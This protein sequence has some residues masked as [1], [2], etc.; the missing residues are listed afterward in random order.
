MI[1]CICKAITEKDIKDCITDCSH[2]SNKDVLH[3]LKIGSS[4]GICKK[5]VEQIIDKIRIEVCQ[6]NC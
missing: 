3:C 4:C 6:E 1:A 2:F 5:E